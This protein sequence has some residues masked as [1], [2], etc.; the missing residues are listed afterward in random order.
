MV[1]FDYAARVIIIDVT[2]ITKQVFD[3]GDFDLAQNCPRAPS[4]GRGPKMRAWK[5]LYESANHWFI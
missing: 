1:F 5:V 3:S 4:Q 2:Q